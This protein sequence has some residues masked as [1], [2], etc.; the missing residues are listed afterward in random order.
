M[1]SF[2][3]NVGARLPSE[4]KG[5]GFAYTDSTRHEASIYLR[6]VQVVAIIV[7]PAGTRT[8]GG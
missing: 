2:D 4:A 1:R 7:P 8:R 6:F 5:L 3:D